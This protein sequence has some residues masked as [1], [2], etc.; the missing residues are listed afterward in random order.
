MRRPEQ[1]YV[2][3]ARRMLGDEVFTQ[4]D[5]LAMHKYPHG[6]QMIEPTCLVFDPDKVFVQT[7]GCD[8][9]SD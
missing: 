7:T 1:L 2:R 9:V 8:A 3:E 6:S 4:N 5:V